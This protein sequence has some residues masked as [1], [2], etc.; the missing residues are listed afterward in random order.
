MNVKAEFEK[1][2]AIADSGK[3]SYKGIVFNTVD[4]LDKDNEQLKGRPLMRLTGVD[5]H[6]TEIR[7][8]SHDVT[9]VA[10]TVH[11]EIAEMVAEVGVPEETVRKGK[12][13]K[14]V[15]HS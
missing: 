4:R 11:E 7:V 9:A 13:K 2:Q 10:K 6:G 3:F 15:P 12:K 1:L 8:W 5:S 14:S